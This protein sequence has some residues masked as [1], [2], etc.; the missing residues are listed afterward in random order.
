MKK[1]LR[2]WLNLLFMLVA[3]A[4]GPAVG[5]FATNY[6]KTQFDKTFQAVVDLSK[7]MVLQNGMVVDTPGGKVKIDVPPDAMTIPELD[8]I[9]DFCDSD[10]NDD[11]MKQALCDPYKDVSH[12]RIASVVGLIATPFAPLL[13]SIALLSNKRK[14]KKKS[15]VRKAAGWAALKGAN[16]IIG[17]KSAAFAYAGAIAGSFWGRIPGWIVG[18]VL[19]AIL[20]G[21]EMGAVE[22]YTKGK[23]T[24]EVE[25]EPEVPTPIPQT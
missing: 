16:K 19:F 17:L 11:Q 2:S 7:K 22:E 5:Y 9:D 18:V 23:M 24:V 21:I 15:T 25:F 4:I 13:V 1:R 10:Y 8:S 3:F 14:R 6:A 20:C 12:A